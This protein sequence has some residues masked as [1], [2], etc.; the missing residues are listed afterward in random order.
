[1]PLS[2]VLIKQGDQL[3]IWEAGRSFK[4]SFSGDL[5][6]RFLYGNIRAAKGEKQ[7]G[8]YSLV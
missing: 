8:R 7:I 5:N 2:C 6:P 3:S 1:M 4:F